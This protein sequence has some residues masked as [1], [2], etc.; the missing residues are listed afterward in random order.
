MFKLTGAAAIL[1]A[2]LLAQTANADVS[3]AEAIVGYLMDEKA[4]ECVHTALRDAVGSDNSE[5]K[6]QSKKDSDGDFTLDLTTFHNTRDF[7]SYSA[8]VGVVA[9]N[10]GVKLVGFSVSATDLFNDRSVASHSA[11][12]ITGSYDNPKS[13]L[14][15]DYTEA[16]EV[17][18][19]RKVWF[20]LYNEPIGDYPTERL[21][22]ITPSTP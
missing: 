1:S 10:E 2:G 6:W 19:A 15:A 13:Q 16:A 3:D 14:L 11:A 17:K 12:G 4:T 18:L 22:P 5:I 21:P 7:T 20:C 9:A 8:R